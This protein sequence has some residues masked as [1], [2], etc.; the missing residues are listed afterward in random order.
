MTTLTTS[1][2]RRLRGRAT[3]RD[4]TLRA[5]A[6]VEEPRDQLPPVEIAPNDPLLA[7]LQSANGAVDVEELELRSPAL[8]KMRENGV[9]LA[10]PLVSQGELIGVLN[11]GPRRSEQEYSSDDRKLLDKLAAQAAPALR[12]GQLVLEQ[13]AEAATR[14]RFEQELEVARLIQQ[15]FLPKQLPQLPNWQLAAYYRPA[16]EVGGDFYD[17]IPVGDGRIGLV[18]GDVTDKGVPAAL[19]MAATRSVLRA[20]AAS[21][22]PVMT[23]PT[24]RPSPAPRS[25]ARGACH[26]D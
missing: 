20:S 24:S 19:V 14:Q 15:N 4:D 26:S 5:R 12:V 10:V 21:P 22:T 7:Y 9:K 3:E 6:A 1:F 23:F 2:R 13:Q 16:R 8:E 11:L 18:I 17:V 25:C